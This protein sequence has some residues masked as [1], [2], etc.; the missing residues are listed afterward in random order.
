[1]LY[2][3]QP[4]HP[5]GKIILNLCQESRTSEKRHSLYKARREQ[6]DLLSPQPMCPLF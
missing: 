6:L 1:M 3:N 2:S 5:N 4:W